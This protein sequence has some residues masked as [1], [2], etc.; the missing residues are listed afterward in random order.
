MYLPQEQSSA[1]PQSYNMGTIAFAYVSLR[2]D[3]FH[4]NDS[5]LGGDIPFIVNTEQFQVWSWIGNSTSGKSS[6]SCVYKSHGQQCIILA[7][8]TRL[9]E[10]NITF[11][12]RPI[13]LSFCPQCDSLG[14]QQ[15]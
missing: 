12:I 2:P 9:E 14:V 4:L 6:M 11:Y 5:D 15:W 13:L 10:V 3:T 1:Y 8:P 7:A